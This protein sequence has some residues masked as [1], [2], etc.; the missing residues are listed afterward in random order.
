MQNSSSDDYNNNN[1]RYLIYQYATEDEASA[2]DDANEDKYLPTRKWIH[3]SVPK[4]PQE[5]W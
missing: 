4:L 2:H 5:D 1:S 3:H